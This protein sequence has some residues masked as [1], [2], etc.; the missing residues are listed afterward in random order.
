M[1]SGGCVFIDHAGG[2]V[3]IKHQVDINTTGTVKAKLT[4]EREDQ[5]QGVMINVYHTENGIFNTSKFMEDLLKQKQKIR[6]NGAGAS[7]KNGSEK[8]NI[9]MV[10]TMESDILMQARMRNAV[11]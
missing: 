11:N 9:N 8:R 3:R 5:G 7:Y 2:Y 4:F 6:F 1:F 10:V